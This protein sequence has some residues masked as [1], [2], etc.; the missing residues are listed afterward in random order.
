MSRIRYACD[1]CGT[2]YKSV[3]EAS[4]CCHPEPFEV[5]KRKCGHWVPLGIRRCSICEYDLNQ[6]VVE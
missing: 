4:E 5:T 2:V 3:E 6:V 1:E